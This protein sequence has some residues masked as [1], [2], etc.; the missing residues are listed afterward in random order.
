MRCMTQREAEVEHGF[1]SK[2]MKIMK[3]DA[4]RDLVAF[5][6]L[7]KHKNRSWTTVTFSK[8]NTPLYV[9]SHILNLQMVPN[10]SKRPIIQLTE[11]FV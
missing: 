5:A 3:C 1:W 4:L 7:K 11:C 8:G 9:F 6:Q 10:C 2:I